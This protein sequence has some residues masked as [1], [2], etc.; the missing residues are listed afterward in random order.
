MT[1]NRT[2]DTVIFVAMVV[3]SKMVWNRYALG[4][5]W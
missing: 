5:W 4:T 1:G 2:L 3:A